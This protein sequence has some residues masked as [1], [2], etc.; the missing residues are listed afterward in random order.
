MN[1]GLIEKCIMGG[2]GLLKEPSGKVCFISYVLPGEK[3]SYEI[4]NEH[5]AFNRARLLKVLEPSSLRIEPKC[6]HYGVCQGCQLQHAPI[7]W[8][9][10]MKRSW[11]I[12]QV[13]RTCK[14][15]PPELPPMDLLLEWQYRRVADWHWE[16]GKL[17]YRDSL[18]ALIPISTCE[19][20]QGSSQTVKKASALMQELELTKARIRWIQSSNKTIAV[21]ELPSRESEKESIQKLKALWPYA[22]ING[23][24][25]VYQHQSLFQIGEAE[26]EEDIDGLLISWHA[27]GFLQNHL[28]GS[29]AFYKWLA[30]RMKPIQTIDNPNQ[31]NRNWLDL[32]CG[33]GITSLMAARLGW[34]VLGLEISAEAIKM[35][36]KNGQ[37]NQLAKQTHFEVCDL[38]RPLGKKLIPKKLGGILVNP[39]RTG[40][41]QPLLSFIQKSNCSKLLYLSC[42]PATF[43]R[44]LK[45]LLVHGF[46][47][48]D[49]KAFDCF[50][51]TSHF[52]TA[53]ELIRPN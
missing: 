35:A 7:D 29:L 8:Q 32:Y 38:N 3:V 2:D 23:F 30:E 46:Q 39:P 36:H 53:A 37:V 13:K 41:S 51:Q 21:I 27:Q 48:R 11:L 49:W 40:L 31:L 14:I 25:L 42:D 22:G 19:I 10:D 20:V 28:Q 52:E 4:T 1:E 18:G 26:I 5:K 6:P 47:L 45:E 34:Q 15:E 9:R 44:D 43:C 24:H 33:T 12:E 16:N 50:G 17:G